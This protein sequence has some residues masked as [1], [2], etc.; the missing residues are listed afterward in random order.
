MAHNPKLAD[1]QEVSEL[2]REV[3]DKLHVLRE[4]LVDHSIN[5]KSLDYTDM[6]Y[7]EAQ[8]QKE[9]YKEWFENEQLLQ[10]LWN[11]PGDDNYIR[12]WEFPACTC[13][14]MDNND[15][16]PNGRY[17]QVQNCPIHGWEK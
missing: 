17:V 3:I 2:N 4:L 16:Y 1:K 7:S 8:Y 11:F 13:P 14:K 15:N 5:L 10:K 9:T 6:E 12:F